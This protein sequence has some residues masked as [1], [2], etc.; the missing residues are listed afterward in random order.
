[1]VGVLLL[2]LFWILGWGDTGWTLIGVTLGVSLLGYWSILDL[3]SGWIHDDQ[4]IVIDEVVGLFTTMIFVP[5]SWQTLILALFLF[6]IF[7]IWKPL[8]IR[9]LDN[10]DSELSV[11][12]DDLLAGV[13]ANLTLHLLIIL[14][15]TYDLW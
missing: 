14:L 9:R 5:I 2:A 13:Y 11:I 15:N 10:L 4:R 3:P 6:R 8:G 1:V 7:D 12:V